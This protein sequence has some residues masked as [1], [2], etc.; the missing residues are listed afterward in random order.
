M[1]S[2]EEIMNMINGGKTTEEIAAEF[3]S[4]LNEAEAETKRID[5]EARAKADAE[6]LLAERKKQKIEDM[7]YIIEAVFDYLHEWYPEHDE[8]I[9]LAVEDIDDDEEIEELVVVLDSY[10]ALI[11]SMAKLKEAINKPNVTTANTSIKSINE[12]VT[13]SNE[14]ITFSQKSL[15]KI[16]EEFFNHN[17]I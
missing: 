15:D 13:L 10:I 8:L 16:F 17:G 6:A 1:F 3:A 12:P 5:E 9:S 7:R 4:A 14:A 2:K 11:A